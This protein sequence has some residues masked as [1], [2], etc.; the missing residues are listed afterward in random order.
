MQPPRSTD[1]Q[2]TDVVSPIVNPE[3]AL[4]LSTD[5]LSLYTAVKQ[6][7]SDM[8]Q[9]SW[10]AGLREEATNALGTEPRGNVRMYWK[11]V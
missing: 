6:T 2:R 8:H 4:C 10:Q 3:D 1:L 11:S 9:A 7:Q 5:E